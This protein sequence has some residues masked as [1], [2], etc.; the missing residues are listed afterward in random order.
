MP[1]LELTNLHAIAGDLEA[2]LIECQK[3]QQAK[4]TRQL[5]LR[6]H[7]YEACA[8]DEG[9]NDTPAVSVRRSHRKH[10]G[11]PPRICPRCLAVV[12]L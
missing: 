11:T 1:V 3:V 8:P 5:E 10:P 7:R 6:G 9:R 2:A 4:Q 12:G